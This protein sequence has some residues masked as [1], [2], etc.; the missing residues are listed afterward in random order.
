[1]LEEAYEAASAIDEESAEDLSEELGDILLQ[2]LF[3]S[4]IAEDNECFSLDDVIDVT[5]KKLLRRHPHV[6]RDTEVS[7]GEDS[8]NVWEQVK[9]EEKNHETTAAAMDSVARAI[10]ALWRAEKIQKKAAKTGFDWQDYTGALQA[11]HSELDE[12]ESAIAADDKE[13][14]KE[15]FGD[16]LFSVVNTARFQGVD[17]EDALN[18]SSDKFVSRFRHIEST[19]SKQGKTLSNMTLDEMEDLYIQAKKERTHARTDMTE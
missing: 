10:P 9:R 7:N 3:H 15:E 16:L 14:I 2:V 13:A 11:L 17:P 4:D 12:L 8:L 6:F 5:C 19:A 18:A 1:L